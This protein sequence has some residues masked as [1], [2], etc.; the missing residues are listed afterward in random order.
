M[1]QTHPSDCYFSK[2]AWR[3]CD[4]CNLLYALDS[5]RSQ[6]GS[7]EGELRRHIDCSKEYGKTK[8][9]VV[10]FNGVG[11]SITC[12]WDASHGRPSMLEVSGPLG[13]VLHG[14]DWDRVLY[15]EQ[16]S[17]PEIEKM[18]LPNEKKAPLNKEQEPLIQKKEVPTEKETPN[19]KQEPPVG[20]M[21]PLNER[22]KKPRTKK[23]R[24]RTQQSN[25]VLEYLQRGAIEPV[26]RQKEQEKE[27][28]RKKREQ[29]TVPPD[30]HLVCCH[31]IPRDRFIHREKD[32]L[33]WET[34][35]AEWQKKL[36]K[37]RDASPRPDWYYDD[38]FGWV[39][40]MHGYRKR[41][42][43]F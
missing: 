23:K 38:F 10:M 25:R 29:E 2:G 3:G 41:R 5:R 9:L 13:V 33:C 35:D 36:I 27:M 24:P 6:T 31:D 42:L 26:A 1:S 32:G 39:E 15:P 7:V 37:R 43:S 19:D 22:K 28:L 21:E 4:I 16:Q 14:T 8:E 34:H 17:E 12:S 30:A 20:N 18:E 11:L 40:V